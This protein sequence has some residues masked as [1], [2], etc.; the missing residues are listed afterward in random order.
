[1]LLTLLTYDYIIN[2]L[3]D[4]ITDGGFWLIIDDVGYLEYGHD[5]E[6]IIVPKKSPVIGELEFSEWNTVECIFLRP[7]FSSFKTAGS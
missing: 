4:R 3:P 7:A 5:W 1:M 2:D 6:K